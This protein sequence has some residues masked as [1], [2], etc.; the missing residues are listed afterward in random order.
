MNG[1]KDSTNQK[2]KTDWERVDALTDEDIRRAIAEDP[3]A[4]PE[5]TEEMA[6]LLR[7][8]EEVFPEI[9][10]A[11]RARRGLQKKPRKVPVSIRLDPD[12]VEYFRAGGEGWQSR[13]NEV[14]VEY[15]V[16]KSEPPD[17]V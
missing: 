1:K 5:L 9:V 4:A 2:S 15:V 7:P 10:A 14:L 16:E 3:D 8:A 12:V 11:Y 17:A 6:A 13:I